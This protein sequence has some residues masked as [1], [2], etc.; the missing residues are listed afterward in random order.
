[1][2][3]FYVILKAPS[4]KIKDPSVKCNNEISIELKY[5]HTLVKTYYHYIYCYFYFT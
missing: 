5:I 3:K 2:A 4:N 1:M